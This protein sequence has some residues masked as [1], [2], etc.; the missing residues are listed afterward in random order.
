MFN[1]VQNPNA[2]A[3]ASLKLTG[4]Y[5]LY[6]P[7][8]GSR[9]ASTPTNKAIHLGHVR[10]PAETT[11]ITR[12]KIDTA[13]YGPVTTVLELVTKVEE[14]GTFETASADD[15]LI[16]GLWAGSKAV[17]SAAT[18]P[19]AFQAS[20]VYALGDE[21]VPATTNGHYYRVTTAGTSDATEPVSYSTTGGTTASGTAT[22][23]DLSLLSARSGLTV[24]RNNH[25]TT[26]GML[27]DVY[28]SAITGANSEIF[29]APSATLSGDGYGAGRDG[30]NETTLKFSYTLLSPGAYQIPS[31]L[32]NFGT[33]QVNGGLNILGVPAGGEDAVIQ[34]LIDGFNT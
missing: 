5:R 14:T 1:N 32:G 15:I 13:V 23:T 10:T 2:L 24:V 3:I 27:I 16:R 30:T 8:A 18:S 4:A 25:G 22:F 12:K 6:V 28:L 7:T 29:V 20:H 33:E 17:S 21:L 31:A 9:F 19:A 26:A 11:N 34:A